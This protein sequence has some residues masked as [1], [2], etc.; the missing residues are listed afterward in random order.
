MS[1][2]T[3]A[4][5]WPEVRSVDIE[6]SVRDRFGPGGVVEP[7]DAL[8]DHVSGMINARTGGERRRIGALQLARVHLWQCGAGDLHEVLDSHSAEWC[9]YG[10]L[11][12][13]RRPAATWP[14]HLLILDRLQLIADARGRDLGLHAAARAIRSWEDDSLVVL[15][16]WP[17][18][19][20]GI[21]GRAGA[22]ALARHW[23]RLG[24]RRLPQSDPPILRAATSALGDTLAAL[25]AWPP[26]VRLAA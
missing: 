17:P 3:R 18:G 20:S 1:T 24:L 13:L 16:A 9:R 25:S 12:E 5:P 4:F 2:E 15:T 19:S 8:V 6:Y 26:A 23:A 14:R 11:P 10:Q 22:A 21:E 7:C